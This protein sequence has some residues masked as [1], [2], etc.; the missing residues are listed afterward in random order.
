MSDEA[1]TP[2]VPSEDDEADD[3]MLTELR[4]L[5]ARHDPV[6]PEA[7]AAA[8]SAMAWRTIDAELAELTADSLVDPAPAGVRGAAT[9]AL[10]SFEAAS[11]AVEVEILVDGGR[12]RLVGQLV[13]PAPGSVEV[14]HKGGTVRVTADEVGRFSA[15]GIAP[16]PVSLRCAAGSAT[17]QTDW[18]L[19]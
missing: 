6:P 10:L 4:A 16:G 7:I 14:R 19:A 17:A 13:P 11:L 8:R 12:R 18:F 1:D 5:A 15:A 9:P 2:G 3:V